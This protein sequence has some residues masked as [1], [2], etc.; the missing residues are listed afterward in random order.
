M[1]PSPRRRVARTGGRIRPRRK[2]EWADFALDSTTAVGAVTIV[3]VLSTFAA[4]P[5][6]SVSG[7]TVARVHA[8]VSISSAVVVGDGINLGFIVDQTN[9]TVAGPG[10]AVTTPHVISVTETP[11]ADWM[12]IDERDARPGYNLYGPNNVWTYDVRAKR[13]LREIGDSL[14]FVFENPDASATVSWFIHCRTLLM[15]P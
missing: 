8:Y 4:L 12:M 14:L 15:M 10:V 9:E 7:A 1:P 3:D 13:R 2:V 11:N 5:G 6:A